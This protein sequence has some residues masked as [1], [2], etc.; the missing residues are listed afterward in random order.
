MSQFN[1]NNLPS[2][3]KFKKLI[4][5]FELAEEKTEKLAILSTSTSHFL[6]EAIRFF[7]ASN[8]INVSF[9][10]VNDNQIDYYLLNKS[11]EYYKFNPTVTI[12]LE[13]FFSF[14]KDLD[15]SK[16]RIA[17]EVNKRESFF[18][19]INQSTN[20]TIIYSLISSPPYEA[21]GHYGKSCKSSL[22]K[23]IND[24]NQLIIENTTTSNT[25][26]IFFDLESIS[27]SI[28]HG[29]FYDLNKYFESK[30]LYSFNSLPR[31][32]F[33][34]TQL[35]LSSKGKSK[36]CLILD[37][38]NT[39]WGGV[40]GDDGID[41][42]KLGQ[43]DGESEA[44]YHF[45]NYVLSLKNRGVIL[46]ICSKNT[47]EIAKAVFTDHPSCPLSWSDISSSRI[48]WDN[49]ADNIAEIAVE[50]NIGL[51][52]MVFMDDNPAE[53]EIVK[54][55]LPQVTVIQASKNPSEFVSILE[56]FRL[57]ETE[58]LSSEDIN[59]SNYYAQNKERE[60]EKEKLVDMDSFLKSLKMNAI[61]S[62]IN[63]ENIE[64]VTQLINKSNQF[65]LMT[66]RHG[67][68]DINSMLIDSK[69]FTQTIRL[70]DKFGDNG[71]I[72]VLIGKKEEDALLI[73]TLLMSCRVLNRGV[74]FLIFQNLINYCKEN[75]IS[76][77]IGFY[78][79]TPK[80]A[81]VKELYGK[82]GGEKTIESSEY[83][84]WSFNVSS[85]ESPAKYFIN[86]ET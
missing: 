24:F 51:D 1:L 11:S 13:D 26:P 10:E 64:R 70:K 63:N 44:F 35:F 81:L 53:C 43:G 20:S 8:G 3:F 56:S 42:I 18:N 46:A 19:L 30:V 45:Q 38:D 84:T 71:L 85:W 14:Q 15:F 73:D 60:K 12:I 59:R 79:P 5:S 29:E 7:M 48:N 66:K 41:G 22:R 54:V 77:V 4:R 16:D 2:F 31:I 62:P 83:D 75:S 57:F 36:K 21:Y 9:F 40:I 37:L 61:I 25:S 49:K 68:N 72:S 39:C 6:S 86:E 47:H 52:S 76:K 23:F 27:S 82:L 28:G 50:L 78:S 34:L 17:Q 58:G 65:N 33:E 67:T 69:Y 55:N 74:E 80:N 32:A